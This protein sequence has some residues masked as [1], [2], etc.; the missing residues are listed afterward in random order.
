M[1]QFISGDI[2]DITGGDWQYN[3]VIP[4]Y[5]MGCAPKYGN[6]QLLASENMAVV[7]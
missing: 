6:P 2:P 4:L 7:C 3:M 5:R 1:V